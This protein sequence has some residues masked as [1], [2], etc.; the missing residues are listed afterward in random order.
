MAETE[1][2]GAR[3]KRQAPWPAL[4]LLDVMLPK[5]SGI[6]VCRELRTRSRVPIIMVTA[7]TSEIDAVVGLE[8]GADDAHGAPALDEPQPVRTLLEDGVGRWRRN[9]GEVEQRLRHRVEPGGVEPEPVD[10]R[11]RRAVPFGGRRP[12]QGPRT[13]NGDG[14]HREKCE[15]D[16]L[17]EDEVHQPPPGWR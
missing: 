17:D 10:E 12:R 16:E 13:A 4:V 3:P 9:V 6:D 5:I 2:E 15:R 8:V 11:T 7:K 1:P 14:K